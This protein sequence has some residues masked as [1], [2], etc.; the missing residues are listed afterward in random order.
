MTAGI[1]LLERLRGGLPPTEGPPR[2]VVIVGAGI[3]GL[4]AGM[5]LKEAGHTVT[6]LGDARSR[7]ERRWV[8][9]AIASAVT[10]ASAIPA[11]L[12]NELPAVTVQAR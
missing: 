4:T 6:L 3:A 8:E 5:L 12:R 11:G 10:K 2:H 7:L 9:G 1:D